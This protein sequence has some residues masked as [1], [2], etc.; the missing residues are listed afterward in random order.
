MMS[1]FRNQAFA[2]MN[3]LIYLEDLVRTLDHVRISE[4][5]VEAIGGQD[6]VTVFA[7]RAEGQTPHLRLTLHRVI[8]CMVGGPHSPGLV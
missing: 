2:G 7:P 1:I 4:D 6:D 8:E 5:V 3:C